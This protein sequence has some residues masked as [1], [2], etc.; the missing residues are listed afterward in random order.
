MPDNN[1]YTT[2]FQQLFLTDYQV[3]LASD[4]VQLVNCCLQSWA[5]KFNCGCKRNI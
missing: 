4:F 1:I 2:N 5:Q 3:L